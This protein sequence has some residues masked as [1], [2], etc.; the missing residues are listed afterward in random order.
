MTEVMPL[1]IFLA[2]F[3]KFEEV[4]FFTD[5]AVLCLNAGHFKLLNEFIV[6]V[7]FPADLTKLLALE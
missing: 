4:E 1:E 3:C 5:Q 6:E 7:I 2:K